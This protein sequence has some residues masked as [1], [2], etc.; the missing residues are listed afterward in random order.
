MKRRIIRDRHRT[1][2]GGG[3]AFAAALA[4]A[5]F[6][7]SPGLAAGAALLAAWYVLAPMYAFAFGHVVLGALFPDGI[8]AVQFAIVELGLLGVLIEPAIRFDRRRLLTG[9]VGGCFLLLGAL[10][11]ATHRWSGVTWHAALVLVGTVA[12]FAYGIHRYD[13]VVLGFEGRMSDE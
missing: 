4:L 7:G 9:L 6:H 2:I 3:G 13:S 10:V 11:W 1:T 12:L 5:A 8:G